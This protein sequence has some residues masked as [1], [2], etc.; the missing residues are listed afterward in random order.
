MQLGIPTRAAVWAVLLVSAQ[1]V[2]GLPPAVEIPAALAEAAEAQVGVTTRYDPSY[3]V[4]DY[5]GGDLPP[6]RGVCTDVVIRAF[7]A[8]GIDLQ[9]EVHEDMERHFAAYPQIW[10]LPGPDKNIDHRRV[11]NLMRF[12]ERRGKAVP[13]DGDYRPGDIVAWRLPGG[14]G[15]VGV[16][17]EDRVE[18]TERHYVV[19]NL[20]R[21][22]LAEDVL[23]A[24]EIIGHYRW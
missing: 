23:E 11:P 8:A 20:G 3:I 14:Q 18:G 7:R 13:L 17:A 15:H 2:C 12:F 9:V 6:E 10:G 21:G 19:H 5:P 16:V 1:P 22:T 4:L 24:F